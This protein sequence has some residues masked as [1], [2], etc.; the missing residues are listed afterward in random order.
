[1]VTVQQSM[2]A[3]LINYWYNVHVVWYCQALVCVPGT[4]KMLVW[5]IG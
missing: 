5:Y 2:Q 1:M 4:N 3:K